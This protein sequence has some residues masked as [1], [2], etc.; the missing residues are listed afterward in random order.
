[1]PLS[2][3]WAAA[4][5][6]DLQIFVDGVELTQFGDVQI[7]RNCSAPGL[8][9]VCVAELSFTTPAPFYAARAA[10]IT[11]V[12]LDGLPKF[13]ISKRTLRGGVVTVSCLDKLAFS[14]IMFPVEKL[15]GTTASYLVSSVMSLICLEMFGGVPH[16]G[17]LPS[18][19]HEIPAEMLQEVSCIDV[20]QFISEACCGVW[21]C[22]SGDNLQFLKF[23]SSSGSFDI[24]E[25]AVVDSGAEYTM[26]NIICKTGSGKTY[27]R[28]DVDHIYDTIHI[29]SDLITDEGCGEIW[30]R[31]GNYTLCTWSCSG[32]RLLNNIIPYVGAV[33][34]FAGGGE[35]VAHS[36]SCRVTSAGVFAVLN[37]SDS[38]SDEIAVRG[39]L[40]RSVANCVGYGKRNGNVI[41]TPYQ[42][43]IIVDDEEDE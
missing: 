32:C 7:K 12:G 35:Y 11:V 40:A 42:G 24:T 33:M 14:D 36:I 31:A 26:S 25:H 17:G 22:A 1:M 38:L 16:Y 29:N 9:G 19:L 2:A 15:D 27:W 3:F 34:N 30:G 5:L 4:A 39:A 37:G 41:Q 28:G 43:L 8:S 21:Y 6:F 20:L 13:Y 10:E 18:W 23:G